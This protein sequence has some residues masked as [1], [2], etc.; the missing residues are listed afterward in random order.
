MSIREPEAVE[1]LLD[2][3]FERR[4]RIDLLVNNAG[5]QF[6]QDAID[7]SAR[8]GWRWSTSTSMAHGG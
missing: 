8:A 7:F 3:I 2:D 1:A 5:G 4:G 6:P